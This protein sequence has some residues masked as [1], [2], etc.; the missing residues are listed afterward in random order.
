MAARF[1]LLLI[2]VSPPAT[3]FVRRELP[4]TNHPPRAVARA[5]SAAAVMRRHFFPFIKD[6][7]RHLNIA[8]PFRD[9]ATTFCKSQKIVATLRRYF[10]NRERLSQHCDDI[11]QTARDR[12]NIATMFY[13]PREIVAT[14]RRYF[15]N[16]ERLSQYCDDV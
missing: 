6:I 10:A 8:I 1:Y 12:R 2:I 3:R 9:I 13:K 7:Y 16:R 4:A 5:I 14:L 11:L 15:T